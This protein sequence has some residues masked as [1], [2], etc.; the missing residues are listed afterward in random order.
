MS[1]LQTIRKCLRFTRC[2][3]EEQGEKIRVTWGSYSVFVFKDMP[4]EAAISTAAN[5]AEMF[6]RHCEKAL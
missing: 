6:A 5:L 3:V 4:P 1:T 2:K